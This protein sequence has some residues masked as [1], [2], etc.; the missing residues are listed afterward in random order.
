MTL[1][2]K[3]TNCGE[4]NRESMGVGQQ[5]HYMASTVASHSSGFCF[6][7]GIKP[8]DCANDDHGCSVV[9]SPNQ[10]LALKMN[11]LQND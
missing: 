11:F 5:L 1:I 10:Q 4:E 6:H 2:S 9:V 7:C 8:V 3:K